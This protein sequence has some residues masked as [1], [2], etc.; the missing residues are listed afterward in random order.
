MNVL[1]TG[2]AGYIGGRVA[3]A[4]KSAIP[5][6][7]ITLTTRGKRPRGSWTKDFQIAE[8]PLTDFD[9]IQNV[10]RDSRANVVVHLAAANEI[11]AMENPERAIEINTKGSYRVF[12][13]AVKA[14][15]KRIIYFST[16]HVYGEQ[17]ES[18]ITEQ[19]NVKPV[20]PYAFTHLGA[21]D[22]LRYFRRYHGMNAIVLRLSNGFGYPMD[23]YV[24]RWTLLFN[25]LCRQVVTN[26]KIVLRSSGRQYRDFITLTDVS[27][28][29]VHFCGENLDQQDDGVFNLGGNCTM[30]ILDA[31]S[32]VAEIYTKNFSAVPTPVEVN[33]AAQD[34][35]GAR[36]FIYSI[37]KIQATGFNLAGN[38]DDEILRTI[39][40]CRDAR[41]GRV[42]GESSTLTLPSPTG[43]G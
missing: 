41:E 36:P 27:R 38:M 10:V 5:E 3:T 20:H 13:S 31:A 17:T 28:A 39:Q 34:S 7:R 4:L 24:D 9:S 25:D 12:H 2:G 37:E 15:V 19:T 35:R 14:G 6:G 42:F 21:E 23:P 30:T 22:C 11:E 43:R 8:M 1:I 26:G 29:V 40:F 16:F 33:A 18:I 32:R